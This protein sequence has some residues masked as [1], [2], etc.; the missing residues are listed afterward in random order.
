MDAEIFAGLKAPP[1]VLGKI[2]YSLNHIAM[3]AD[4]AVRQAVYEASI[5]QGVS[6]AE[7]MEKAFEVF[8]VRRKGSSKSLALAGQLIP[9]FNA[10]LAAQN[11]AY[12][13]ITGRGI[14]PTDRQEAFKT[15]AATTASVMTLSLLYAMMNGD[16]EDY[17]KKPATVR[18]RLLMIP[19]TG[20]MSVP[21]RADLFSM[22]KIITEHMYLMMTD[23][24]YEDGRKFRDSMAAAL[25]SS[26][27]G[28]TAVPQAIKPLVEVA[29]NYD[30][31]QGKPLI[32][33]YQKKLDTERQFTDSTSELGK[34]LGQTGLVSPIAADHL[35][36]GMLG[37]VGGLIIYATNP[38]LHSDPNSPRPSLSER[39]AI[40]A[41]PGMGGFMTKSYESALK[42]D[43]Y[44]L[45]EEVDKAANTLNDLKTRSP[46]EIEGFLGKEEN[47][48][49]VGLQ[50]SVNAIGER[51]SNI[52]KAITQ[53]TNSSM[54]A[55]EKQR[56]IEILRNAEEQMLQ[57]VNVKKL[58]ELGKL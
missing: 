36:R 11:V 28:P 39:D 31:F 50:K 12:K 57:G 8:N 37:S 58:R 5:S 14:S 13:T 1:G 24:G 25:G 46:Q 4:N 17:L 26:L 51:L 49:R 35:L 27:L 45:K 18:D 55:D 23:K 6:R 56:Q 53:T 30:F 38:I 2:K 33:T 19:G 43:F 40:A 9:F 47:L 20:G 29:I 42:K 10:Y 22:P 3:S 21:I 44:T 32:G 34:I 16:D 52:R 15:L 41:L 48:A 54:P 7:A